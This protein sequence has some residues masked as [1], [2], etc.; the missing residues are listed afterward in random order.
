M[1]E[2][3]ATPRVQT[4]VDKLSLRDRLSDEEVAAL[5]KALEPPRSVPICWRR[6]PRQ[7]L[8]PRAAPW[9]EACRPGT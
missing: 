4:L 6:E 1:T 3:R 2:T 9:P 7:P 8:P 5:D